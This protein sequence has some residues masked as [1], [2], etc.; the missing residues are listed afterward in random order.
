MSAERAGLQAAYY[1]R[2]VPILG[3]GL[4]ACRIAVC[5]T[6]AVAGAIERLAGCRALHWWIADDAPIT[7]THPLVRGGWGQIGA[8]AGPTLVT[9]L[10]DHNRWEDGWAF[11]QRPSLTTATYPALLTELRAAPPDLLLGGGDTATLRLLGKLARALDCPALLVA[12]YAGADP[13]AAC[14]ALLPGDGGA[15][16]D[17]PDLC[18][19]LGDPLPSDPAALPATLAAWHAWAGAGGVAALLAKALLLHGTSS[20]APDLD[21]LLWTARRT[22]VFCGSPAWPWSVLYVN[23]LTAGRR[24]P[25]GSRQSAVDGSKGSDRILTK[26]ITVT[27][28]TERRTQNSALVI[29]CGSLG[30]WVA[31]GL[32][33]SGMRQLVLVDGERV[34]AANPVRQWFHTDQVGEA[35][36]AAL[37]QNLIALWGADAIWTEAGTAIDG[38]ILSS[39]A[40]H[41]TL[42]PTACGES[43][44]E[45][46]RFRRLLRATRPRVVVLATGSSVD[47]ALARVLRRLNI[48]HLVGRCYPRARYFEVIVVDGQRGPCF[49]CLRSRLYTGPAPAPTPEEALRY[50][51]AIAPG[52]LQAEPATVIE[53]GRA[54]DA[55]AALAAAMAQPRRARPPWLIT[56][57]A[58]ESTCL[59]GGNTAGA[60][61]DPTTGTAGW[62]YGIG[63][64]G[65]L[66]TFGADQ[67]LGYGPAHTCADC[68]RVLRVAYAVKA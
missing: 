52:E 8:A 2:I 51:R 33:A 32:A 46:A 27:Q 64:P 4:R 1:A 15:G 19:A 49:G 5:G 26:R 65:Q 42:I 22:A 10:R 14:L 16:R 57:L 47:Y 53:S 36:V 29:G 23:L 55:L 11:A 28:D 68:G 67:I 12:H 6:A 9:A 66:V 59:I 35:K 17:W 62:V 38:T 30:S 48:P 44:A 18:V 3:D 58:R 31:R 54:A 7:P 61:H 37:A 20:A 41:V 56:L 25:V 39:D 50:D 13:S 24:P 63:L 21:A 45:L 34:D 60:A 40:G 43:R